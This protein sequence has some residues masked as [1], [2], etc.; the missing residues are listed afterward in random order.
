MTP[1]SP[2]EH[3]PLVEITRIGIVGAGQ[4][5]TGI[6]EVV[7]VAGYDVCIMDIAEDR[8]ASAVERIDARLGR[9]VKKET[10]SADEHRAAMARITTGQTMALFGDCNLV[11]EA[12]TEREDIK[13]QIFVDMVPELRADAIIASNTSSISITRLAAS[14]DRPL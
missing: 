8:L 6:A 10:L 1:F 4:M 2:N 14:T 11:I 5:G 12:A 7:S 3:P 13:R 9:R